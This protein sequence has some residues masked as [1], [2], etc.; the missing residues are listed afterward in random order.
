MDIFFKSVNIWQSYKQ[1]R[2]YLVIILKGGE[3]RGEEKREGVHALPSEEKRKL[4]AYESMDKQGT[5][6]W[7]DVRP[8]FSGLLESDWRVIGVE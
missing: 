5:D 8:A 1:N 7:F 6:L 2:D 4:G 3:S